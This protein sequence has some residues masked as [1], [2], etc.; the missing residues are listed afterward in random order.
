MKTLCKGFFLTFILCACSVVATFAAE[1]SVFIDQSPLPLSAPAVIQ[2]DRVLVPM[3]S[4]MEALGYE[5]VWSQTEESI[6]A[7]KDHTTI[8]LTLDHP[9]ARVND[10]PVKLDTPTTLIN[11]TTMVP[12]RFVA[13][14]S[15]AA[16][17][18]DEKSQTVFISTLTDSNGPK[19]QNPADSVV[20]LQTNKVQG[21]GII[22]SED[23][24]IATNYHVL[25][26]ATTLQLVFNDGT[27]YQGETTVV[28]LNQEADI[29]LL[30]IQKTGLTPAN[31]QTKIA[32]GEEV[33]AIGSP[34]GVRNKQT[35]G[36]IKG[37]NQDIISFTAPIDQG[38]SGGALFNK[39]GLLLGMTSAFDPAQSFAIPVSLISRIPQDL[40]IPL[41]EL[42]KLPYSNGPPK[43]LRYT[44]EDDYAYVSWSPQY[45]VDYYHVS[46][47]HTEN[48]VF[49]KMN[50]STTKNDRWYWGFPQ[51]FG[52]STGDGHTVYL[53]VTGVRDG[54][55]TTPSQVLKIN[56]P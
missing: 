37:Y 47:T 36:V 26:G 15:G 16:V 17:R 22:L 51:S 7:T 45:D 41:K 23:G 19:T 30:R 43:N 53:K 12:L 28:G 14:H 32:T 56:F 46:I 50:N 54:V 20:F 49:K 25:K 44:I 13:T 8:F 42:G 5:V 21:S 29:A 39:E 11:E 10:T 27:I 2:N 1:L 18:W 35:S 40:Q 48:G 3:R 52:I 24:L 9:M 6:K 31:P 38:S 33:L 34:L 55:E 4:I